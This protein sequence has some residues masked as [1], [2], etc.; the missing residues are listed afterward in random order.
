MSASNLR[1]W[2]RSD[3]S[4]AKIICERH[5]RYGDGPLLQQ[6]AVENRTKRS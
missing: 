5:R 4:T 3:A 2:W 1:K 6:G